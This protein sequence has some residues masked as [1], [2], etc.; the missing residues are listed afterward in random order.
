VLKK[1]LSRKCAAIR[2]FATLIATLKTR[3]RCTTIRHHN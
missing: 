1:V 3:L 2:T